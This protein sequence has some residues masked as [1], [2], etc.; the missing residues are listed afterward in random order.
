MSQ[1]QSKIFVLR[2]LFSSFPSAFESKLS[3]LPETKKGALWGRLLHLSAERTLP[4]SNLKSLNSLETKRLVKIISPH[5]IITAKDETANKTLNRDL[6]AIKEFLNFV[7]AEPFITSEKAK[8][9]KR[10]AFKKL[11]SE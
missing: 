8:I 6:I 3:T 1:L 7:E 4:I 5:Q 2:V 11:K 9:I 10:V